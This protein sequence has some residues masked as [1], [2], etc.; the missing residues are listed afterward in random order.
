ML[1][2]QLQRPS[3]EFIDWM[4]IIGRLSGEDGK[5]GARLVSA[6]TGYHDA[7][8]NRLADS[9]AK[10]QELGAS[11]SQIAQ[12]IKQEIDKYDELA[13]SSGELRQRLS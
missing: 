13:Q 7:T 1:S 10:L 6:W 12:A 8:I 11:R 4:R 2:G 3:A 9:L 5:Y